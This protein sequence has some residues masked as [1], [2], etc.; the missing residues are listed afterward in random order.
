MP[1]RRSRPLSS[2]S[3]TQ[4]DRRD[5]NATTSPPRSPS[6]SD[7]GDAEAQE[8]SH[9]RTNSRVHVSSPF[10]DMSESQ[11]TPHEIAKAAASSS[12]AEPPPASELGV[13]E[14]STQGTPPPRP[15]LGTFSLVGKVGVV[16]GGA[17][18]LGLVMAK[19]LLESGGRVALVDLNVEEAER[20]AR[21]LSERYREEGAEGLAE[22]NSS[23]AS[24]RATAHYADVSCP[25][26][27]E[28]CIARVI[29]AHGQV[30]H[31]ITS[32]GFTE[33]FPAETYPHERMRKLWGVNV[34]GTYLAAV[35]VAKHLVGRKAGGSLILIGS[36]SG[37]VVN[38]PQPQAPYN[39]S[40][41][42]VRQ[43]AASLAVEWAPHGIRVNCISP[44]YMETAL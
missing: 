33:N 20:Q 14:Q 29:S 27:V 31:L 32:A 21:L 13:P 6:S 10:V 3:S 38:V 43:L 22:D 41:A 40:K 15:T 37:A 1:S 28:D 23:P 42:A 12:V 44:G 5:E 35:V 7:A 30:D 8:A 18:G 9:A 17:R 36:M 24:P 11:R 26:S 2:S 16:T 39:A 4:D 19:A 25:T 34:D